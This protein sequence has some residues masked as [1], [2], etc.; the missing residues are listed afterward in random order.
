MKR[1]GLILFTGVFL[2]QSVWAAQPKAVLYRTDGR[3]WNVDLVSCDA[4]QVIYTLENSEAQKTVALEDINRLQIKHPAYDAAEIETLLNAGDYQAVIRILEPVALSAGDYMAVENNLK[5]PFEQLMRAYYLNGSL[6][7]AQVAAEKLQATTEQEL[8]EMAVV[9]N[10]LSVLAQGDRTTAQI[11]HVEMK[12]SVARQ[13]LK[14]C[15]D[16]NAGDLRSAMKTAVEL[17]AD[18]PNNMTYMPLTELLC[19]QLYIDLGRL[20]SADETARQAKVFYAGTFAEKEAEKLRAKIKELKKE[21]T[22]QSN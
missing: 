14:A 13:Y 5:K 19:A 16:Q 12:D 8:K 17:I 11:L 20:D 18:Y 9:I 3:A 10:G 21:S 15:I 7:D 1:L 6:K 2:M 4:K 22:E